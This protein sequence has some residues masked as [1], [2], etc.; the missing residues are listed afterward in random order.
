[1]ACLY[2]SSTANVRLKIVSKTNL[3]LSSQGMENYQPH[4]E[5]TDRYANPD[6]LRSRLEN[7]KIDSPRY[8]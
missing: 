8:N 7:L 5:S 4:E 3:I 6:N 2:R 1:M